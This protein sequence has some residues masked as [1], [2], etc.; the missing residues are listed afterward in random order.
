MYGNDLVYW[1]IAEANRQRGGQR[2]ECPRCHK[3][4]M[5]ITNSV[6]P[7]YASQFNPGECVIY[8]CPCGYFD[9]VPS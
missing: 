4:T 1:S 6:N 5:K 2:F 9:E 3:T 8:E 7:E